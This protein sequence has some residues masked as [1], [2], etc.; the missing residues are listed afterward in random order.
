[1]FQIKVLAGLVFLQP[2]VILFDR[3]IEVAVAKI[4]IAGLN[5][6]VGEKF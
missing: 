2:R 5:V 6:G 4:E 3:F 1:M